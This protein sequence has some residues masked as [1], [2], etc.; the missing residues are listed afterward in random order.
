MLIWRRLPRPIRYLGCAVF[1]VM[2]L[3]LALANA[4]AD[5]M[6][7]SLDQAQV[8]RLPPGVA[9]IVIGNPLIAD[10]SLQAGG[11]MIV[12]GKG[13]GTTN[14]MALDRGGRVLMEKAIT[15]GGPHSNDLVVVF[16]G[17]DRESY[18]CSPECAPRITALGD[19]TA[20]FGAVLGQSNA[21]SGAAAVTK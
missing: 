12:T 3:G 16:K 18:S 19:N 21:R 6:Q 2:V 11:L 20:Y 13:Y 7:I 15:V 8:M 1:V 9:T 14:L 17:V 4:K 5:T 10:G